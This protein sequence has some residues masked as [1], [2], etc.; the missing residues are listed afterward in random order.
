MTAKSALASLGFKALV[1]SKT[2][3]VVIDESVERQLAEIDERKMA[4]LVRIMELWTTGHTLTDVQF[5]GNEGRAK[6]G[7]LNVMLQAFKTHKVRIFGIVMRLD[8][9][10]TFLIVAVDPAKKQDKADSKI[11]K[12]A[13]ERALDIT[14]A[15]GELK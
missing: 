7:G 12:R 2:A 5:N 1:S 14:H 11:L 3:R 6:R 9:L 15:A 13:Y 10:R 8:G 4:R